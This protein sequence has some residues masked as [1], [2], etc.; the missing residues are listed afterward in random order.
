MDV[1]QIYLCSQVRRH[2]RT[3]WSCQ[4]RFHS[5]RDCSCSHQCW[6]HSWFLREKKNSHIKMSTN[7]IL[8]CQFW[9]LY[10]FVTCGAFSADTNVGI[11]TVLTGAAIS[12]G[13]AKTLIDV[14]LTESACVSR[15]TLAAK[16]C[17]TINAGAV[18]ARVWVA[19]VNICL[20]VS[21]AVTWWT[22]VSLKL[23]CSIEQALSFLSA[24]LSIVS[25]F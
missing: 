15:F 24:S 9:F 20:T 19:F 13:L 1:D 16:R 3:R 17:Q 10:L 14:G 21:A 4:C 12:A 11:L 6:F 2:T 25:T 18:V 5:H 22:E 7:K 23:A 8:C